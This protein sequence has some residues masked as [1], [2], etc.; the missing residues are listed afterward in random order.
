MSIRELAR[1]LDISIGT[2]S[3]ALNGKS[4]VNARTRERVLAAAEALGYVP[5]QSGRSLR[6]GVTNTI[7]FMIDINSEMTAHGDTFFM[8]VF[9]GVQS[10]LARHRLDLAVL[11]RSERDDASGYTRRI[12]ARGAVDGL[13]ISATRRIDPRIDHLVE[14]GLPFVALGRSLSGGGHS[15]IDLDFEGVAEQSVARLAAR[16]HR[17]IAVATAE[18]DVNLGYV[19]VEGYRRALKSHGIAPDPSLVLRS[20]TGEAGGY[21]VGEVLLAM[22]DP[23]TAILLVNEAMAI[24]LYRKLYEV[25]LSPGRHLAIIGFRQSPQA[26]FLAPALTCFKVTLQDVGVRLAEALLAAMPAHA[27]HYRQGVVQ[28]IWPMQLVAGE[29]DD[30]PPH[31]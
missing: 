17:R 24:G 9:D 18:S 10:V 22:R 14:R 11:L 23:P 1:R 2:V 28:E 31:R 3:R 15:W 29:S 4:D 30:F 16:G 8:A 25:G 5:N 6:Q 27:A 26:R 20:R 12:V 7:G 13:I 21:Q 19:F